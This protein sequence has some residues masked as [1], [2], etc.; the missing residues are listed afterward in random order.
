M[1]D[2]WAE[3]RQSH[4]II[5]SFLLYVYRT[6]SNACFLLPLLANGINYEADCNQRAAHAMQ[7]IGI[8]SP[9]SSAIRYIT[10][11]KLR[12]LIVPLQINIK[13]QKKTTVGGFNTLNRV[14]SKHIR[15]S[16]YA[17][18]LYAPKCV[19]HYSL[20]NVS[21]RAPIRTK[22]VM[23]IHSFIADAHVNGNGTKSMDRQT[24]GTG[25]LSKKLHAMPPTLAITACIPRPTTVSKPKVI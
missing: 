7:P 2:G 5:E 17:L 16:R 3:R 13:N 8:V 19:A 24:G 11:K 6:I 1:D 9:P 15:N 14:A 18:C 21:T 23:S 12:W 20:R 10:C 22:C 4:C 25:W